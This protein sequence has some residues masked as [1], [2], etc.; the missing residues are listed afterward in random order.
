MNNA[1]LSHIFDDIADRSEI[2]GENPFAVRAYRA[3]AETVSGYE[4]QMKDIYAE[5][6]LPALMAI[7][8]I[9]KEIAKK[10]ESFLTAGTLAFYDKLR[11]E[12]P[13]GVAEMLKVQ[14]LG[15]KR[16]K[17]IWEALGADTLAKLE[18]A[19]RE[20]KIAQLPKMGAKSEKAILDG[21]E[22]LK[23][24]ATG[25]FLVGDVAPIADGILARLNAMPQTKNAAFAG[26]LR[27]GKETI[28]DAS[29]C[30]KRK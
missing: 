26:S 21:I 22:A 10:I 19:A 17:Q 4:R 9:G 27:R 7:S 28:G 30:T 12:V 2:R 15:P 3:A 25:R 5:G 16:V 1:Q 29:C 18:A 23:K 8:G 24:R 13:D 14:G 11:A 20:G 6:G